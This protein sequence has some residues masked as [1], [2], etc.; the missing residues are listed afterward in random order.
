MSELPNLELTPQFS[1]SLE[2]YLL[3]LQTTENLSD[4]LRFLWIE[5]YVREIIAPLRTSGDEIPFSQWILGPNYALPL[6]IGLAWFRDFFV[7]KI[8]YIS[9]S[10]LDLRY[11]SRYLLTHYHSQLRAI[12]DQ[13]REESPLYHRMIDWQFWFF[14]RSRWERTDLGESLSLELQR[15]LMDGQREFSS[16][17]EYEP[18]RAAV[19]F[20]EVG[21]AAFLIT[22]LYPFYELFFQRARNGDSGPHPWMPFQLTQWK[23]L[24]EIMQAVEDS[25][26]D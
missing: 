2:A 12:L 21:P 19:F 4:C 17:L 3:L 5:S 22:P 14:Q 9:Q 1:C 26:H 25:I 24:P 23:Q 10:A 13:I 15:Q 6:P 11:H 8:Q 18:N 7:E 20:R 16:W